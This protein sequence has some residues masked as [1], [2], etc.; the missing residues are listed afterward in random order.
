MEWIN[1]NSNAVFNYES[2]GVK[3]YTFATYPFSIEEFRHED[4]IEAKLF[5]EQDIR[6]M[7]LEQWSLIFDGNDLTNYLEYSNLLLMAFRVSS[8]CQAPFIKFR[9]CN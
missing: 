3:K 7:K 8:P 9:I 5:S 4:V 1:A 6:H 2:I